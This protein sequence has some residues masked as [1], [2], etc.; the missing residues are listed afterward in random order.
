MLYSFWHQRLCT[1][2]FYC[3]TLSASFFDK[4][5]SAHLSLFNFFE[6][7]LESL[8]VPKYC[9]WLTKVSEL[10]IQSDS[11][12]SK[13]RRAAFSASQPKPP[14]DLCQSPQV[15]V[16]WQQTMAMTNIW[17]FG[18]KGFLISYHGVLQALPSFIHFCGIP[19][20]QPLLSILNKA[21]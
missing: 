9:K 11:L 14:S 16:R 10:M 19:V 15:P 17:C 4:L 1:C 3:N 2:S 20:S 8:M 7:L 21:V 12:T 5:I 13:I 18:L 6:I